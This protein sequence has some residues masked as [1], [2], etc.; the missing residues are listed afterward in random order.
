MIKVLTHFETW[1]L[2][3][4]IIKEFESLPETGQIFKGEGFDYI[5]VQ[6]GLDYPGIGFWMILKRIKQ[7]S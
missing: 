1:D 6:N 2:K 5:V 4:A 7:R 3:T